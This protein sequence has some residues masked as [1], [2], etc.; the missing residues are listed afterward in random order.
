MSIAT[1]KPLVKYV[2]EVNETIDVEY[3]KEY[4]T[5]D[6]EVKWE[7]PVF[8]EKK[9]VAV[10]V[11]LSPTKIGLAVCSPKDTFR[12]KLAKQIATARANKEGWS[13][14]KFLDKTFINKT[15]SLFLQREIISLHDGALVSLKDEI[16]YH[17]QEMKKRAEKYFKAH[18]PPG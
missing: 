10:I 2:Y 18:A 11:A 1:P 12:K 15:P 6:N 16:L 5:Y 9:P 14:A 8:L 17:L 13:A 4:N 3:E 7:A